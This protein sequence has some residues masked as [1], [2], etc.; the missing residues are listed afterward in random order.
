[1]TANPPVPLRPVIRNVI[2]TVAD[3]NRLSA[4][5][6]ACNDR[7]ADFASDAEM[8]LTGIAMVPEA[9][10]LMNDELTGYWRRQ[11]LSLPDLEGR[12]VIIGAGFA[13]GVYA[14]IRVRAGFP[15]PVVLERGSAEQVGG[16]F[17]MS[18][19]PVFRL[20]SRSRPGGVG[21]PDQDMALNY[22]PGALVQP[23]MLSSE[24]YLT[25]ADMA[26]VIR[27]TLAQFADVYPVTD[28]TRLIPGSDTSMILETSNGSVQASRVLDARGTGNERGIPQADGERILTFSQ[29][30]AR[31]GGTFPLR[32]ARQ[33]AVIG[34]G[35]AGLCAAESLLGIAPGNSSAIGLDYVQR[36][37]LYTSGTIDGRTCDSFRDNSRGRYIRLAQYLAG[38]VSNPT[39]RLRIM[40]ASGYVTPLGDGSVLVND[41]VYDLAVLCTGSTLPGLGDD[42]SYF[43]VRRRDSD[44][45]G[46]MLARQA[47]PFESYRIGVAADLPFSDSEVTAGVSSPPA[48]K[49]AMFRLAPRIAALAAMLPRPEKP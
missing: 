25:N 13:A 19:A 16:A 42:L 8:E 18:L 20:N 38:N 39:D 31:M 3:K 34:A 21:L 4:G 10:Q 26:W 32:G 44:G 33:V 27:L 45:R 22:L 17:A 12:E 28:V 7:R 6:T 37:D 14:A 24:E 35:N 2:E 40:D 23:S 46:T 36:V 15:R 47:S 29:M 30:M 9:R 49:V 43:S 5:L 48:N 11:R 41:R 1:M